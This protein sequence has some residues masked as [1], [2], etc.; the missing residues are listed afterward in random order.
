[1]IIIFFRLFIRIELYP[2]IS[3]TCFINKIQFFRPFS[4]H[5]W[6]NT[7]S[8]SSH[9]TALFVFFLKQKYCDLLLRSG[10]ER[11]SLSAI[12]KEKVEKNV[13]ISESTKHGIIIYIND[14]EIK[15]FIK[16]TSFWNWSS[17]PSFSE[18]CLIVINEV[19]AFLRSTFRRQV[20]CLRTNSILKWLLR[21]T[22][23]NT[24]QLIEYCYSSII[25]KKVYVMYR[26]K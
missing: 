11:F 9:T 22:I 15:M 8:H 16:N 20:S 1:M 13:G 14:L 5:A 12:S 18:E 21:L 23:T 3:L 17:V 24:E 19:V 25:I 6:W 26:K 10:L 7:F 4:G 2:K